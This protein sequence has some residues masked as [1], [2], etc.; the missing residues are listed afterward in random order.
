[1]IGLQF[2]HFQLGDEPDGADHSSV[3]QMATFLE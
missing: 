3:N 1:M 2:S